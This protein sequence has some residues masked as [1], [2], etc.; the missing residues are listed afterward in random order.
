MMKKNVWNKVIFAVF[1]VTALVGMAGAFGRLRMGYAAEEQ[2]SV[3]EEVTSG[4]SE[5]KEEPTPATTVQLPE[6][7]KEEVT[8]IRFRLFLCICFGLGLSIV[9]AIWGNPN[10]RLKSRYKRARKLQEKQERE[11][12]AKE[13]TQ[14]EKDDKN[15]NQ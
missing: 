10:E 2:N 4:E 11:R 1:L 7:S 15:K 14:K 9:I 3:T 8:A 6:V 5:E 13:Q 12:L